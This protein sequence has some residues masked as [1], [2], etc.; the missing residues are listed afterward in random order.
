MKE[1]DEGS[2]GANGEPAQRGGCGDSWWE[3]KEGGETDWSEKKKRKMPERN[4]RE[5][6]RQLGSQTWWNNGIQR[7]FLWFILSLSLYRRR[8][9]KNI[10][11]THISLMREKHESMHMKTHTR[12]SWPFPP[13]Q[14]RGVPWVFL[15]RSAHACVRHCQVQHMSA[16]RACCMNMH[17]TSAHAVCMHTAHACYIYESC[18]FSRH[19]V[20]LC[21]LRL[22]VIIVAVYCVRTLSA[23][24]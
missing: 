8:L 11:Y 13:R 2:A 3:E 14:H 17:V 9:Y 20:K 5:G 16:C 21:S 18:I 4:E 23:F 15:W 10:Q 7:A 24:I 1:A 19:V 22:C 12:R 6:G